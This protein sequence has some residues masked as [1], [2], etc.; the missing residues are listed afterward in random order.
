MVKTIL[1]A[2]VSCRN[3]WILLSLFFLVPSAYFQI[4]QKHWCPRWWWRLRT[5][6]PFIRRAAIDSR[7]IFQFP[8]QIE[9]LLIGC[10]SES[11]KTGDRPFQTL[12]LENISF[13][14]HLLDKYSW[15]NYGNSRKIVEGKFDK[16]K[17]FEL[18]NCQKL[19]FQSRGENLNQIAVVT[20]RYDI[21]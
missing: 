14:V 18:V 15:E 8:K 5:A 1:I 20:Y 9:C 4:A 3:F 6:C 2:I 13:P 17:L 19:N 7:C 12:N 10:I 11:P 21:S 16:I